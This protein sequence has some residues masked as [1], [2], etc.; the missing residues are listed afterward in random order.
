[1]AVVAGGPGIA[2]AKKKSDKEDFYFQTEPGELGRSCSG[3]ANFEPY[4][5]G[6]AKATV[7]LLDPGVA[8]EKDKGTCALLIG[9][10]CSHCYCQGWTDKKTGKKAS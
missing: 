4:S 2:Y 9:E 5:G 8:A 1:M 7:S 6:A 3:C 10:V